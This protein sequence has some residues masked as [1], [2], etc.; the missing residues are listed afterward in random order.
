VS[1]EVIS[2]VLAGS[3]AV[4]SL[5][6]ARIHMLRSRR[7]DLNQ[8][9]NMR[10]AWRHREPD[11][12]ILLLMARG[13]D[14]YYNPSGSDTTQKYADFLTLLSKVEARAEADRIRVEFEGPAQRQLLFI[15]QIAGDVLAGRL[16][17]DNADNALCPDVVSNAAA[18][19][20]M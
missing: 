4:V 3:S 10:E 17:L 13:P 15:G 14:S 8:L 20:Q 16:R 12:H 19:R 9:F 18:T 7:D 11:W 1:T 5:W 6:V 2:I